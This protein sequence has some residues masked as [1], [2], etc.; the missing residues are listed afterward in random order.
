MQAEETMK[1]KRSDGHR[2]SDAVP[3]SFDLPYSNNPC[4][5]SCSPRVS[6]LIV[7]IHG[8]HG[9][10]AGAG[11]LVVKCNRMP[12]QAKSFEQHDDLLL[13]ACCADTA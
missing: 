10:G 5:P 4:S 9:V 11:G 12:H 13:R 8:S 1:P 6:I 7:Q 3:Q 2:V